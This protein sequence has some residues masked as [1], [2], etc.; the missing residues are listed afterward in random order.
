MKKHSRGLFLLDY[1]IYRLW[2]ISRWLRRDVEAAVNRRLISR[3]GVCG[4]KGRQTELLPMRTETDYLAV[5]NFLLKN[6]TS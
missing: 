1:C 2:R 5:N 3:L 6:G 4:K